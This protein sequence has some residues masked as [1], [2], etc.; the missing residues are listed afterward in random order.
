MVNNK[1]F[2]VNLEFFV[3][4]DGKLAIGFTEFDADGR[5]IR[6]S[7]LALQEDNMAESVMRRRF[8][9]MARLMGD[10]VVPIVHRDVPAE[11]VKEG[12][13]SYSEDDDL[14]MLGLTR[15][16]LKTAEEWAD[17]MFVRWCNSTHS[18]LDDVVVAYRSCPESLRHEAT[19]RFLARMANR[20]S[21]R[22]ADDIAQVIKAMTEV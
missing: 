16:N 19:L 6:T 20:T 10:R 15:A 11:F 21:M 12:D 4:N 14:F 9:S 3:T 2:K 17:L 18:S 7:I 5:G 1:A 22:A 8:D 13:I